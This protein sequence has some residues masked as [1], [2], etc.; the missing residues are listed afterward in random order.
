MATAIASL[1]AD[2][3]A[4]SRGVYLTEWSATASGVGN[5]LSA[6]DF[7]DKTVQLQGPTGG[8]SRIILEGTNGALASTATW[9]VLT[10]PTDGDIDFT[11]VTGGVLKI[12]RENPRMIR[13]RF[14][15]V[16]SGKTLIVRI[17]S[18]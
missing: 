7:P 13:P 10:T 12:I 15:T 4:I 17:V 16:T 11:N 1:L 2:T 5:P 14:E 3:V 9:I 8:T 6:P 18:R